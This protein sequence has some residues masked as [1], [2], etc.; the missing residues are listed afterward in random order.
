M[1]GGWIAG[2]YIFFVL[3]VGFDVLIEGSRAII[4]DAP[5]GD[6]RY[7]KMLAKGALARVGTGRIGCL[8]TT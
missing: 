3:F 5:V 7:E 8:S 4:A 2:V 1:A 6:E